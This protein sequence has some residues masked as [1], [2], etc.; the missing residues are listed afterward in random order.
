MKPF[1]WSFIIA[2]FKGLILCESIKE[3]FSKLALKYDEKIQFS[4]FF[5]KPYIAQ[6]LLPHLHLKFLQQKCGTSMYIL[7]IV[8]HCRKCKV[9][10]IFLKKKYFTF[11]KIFGTNFGTKIVFFQN[12]I[13]LFSKFFLSI[14]TRRF[15]H[16]ISKRRYIRMIVYN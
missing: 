10:A 15:A 1:K 9:S 5:I 16:K 12:Q 3:P 14:I 8:H 13:S 2:Y 11:Q 6:H 4:T 7:S